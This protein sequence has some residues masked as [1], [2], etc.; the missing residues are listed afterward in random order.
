MSKANAPAWWGAQTVHSKCPDYRPRE[1]RRWRSASTFHPRKKPRQKNKKG[2]KRGRDGNRLAAW[3]YYKSHLYHNESCNC[4]SQKSHKKT[5]NCSCSPTT[6]AG[7][8]SETM[9]L[10]AIAQEC[11]I[12]LTTK[13][14]YEYL[15]AAWPARK[16]PI[17]SSAL[18][19]KEK[20][21]VRMGDWK[22]PN[23]HASSVS[24]VS[25][26]FQTHKK[27]K[28]EIEALHEKGKWGATKT[29]TRR[30]HDIL[31]NLRALKWLNFDDIR[32]IWVIWVTCQATGL[33]G[34]LKI[35]G[36]FFAV[37]INKAVFLAWRRRR[38][39]RKNGC[40]VI[41]WHSVRC[42][43]VVKRNDVHSQR[44]YYHAYSATK[45]KRQQS[46][47]LLGFPASRPLDKCCSAPPPSYFSILLSPW[48]KYDGERWPCFVL[49]FRCEGWCHL[50]GLV[51]TTT[52]E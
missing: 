7:P 24:H 13:P 36:L 10:P 17:S 23:T 45:E 8:P 52:T 37:C 32:G 28:K 35:D 41:M 20:S 16:T 19:V 40:A 25:G 27:K 50:H 9:W 21:P 5:L 51:D 43:D 44:G 46:W 39:R 47:L 48:L 15:K 22:T 31:L 18:S 49:F 11:V 30:W 6:T 38:R 2:P 14:H 3:I 12:S 34:A 29:I 26:I 4:Y 1:E 42:E 33:D